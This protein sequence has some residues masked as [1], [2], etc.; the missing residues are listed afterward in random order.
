MDN[1]GSER[2]V[3]QGGHVAGDG[4]GVPKHARALTFENFPVGYFRMV[5]HLVDSHLP[6]ACGL[7]DNS[8]EAC[9]NAVHRRQ[10]ASVGCYAFL[11]K[12]KDLFFVTSHR[13]M[14]ETDVREFLP[15]CK[16]RWLRLSRTNS[17]LSG[18]ES[19]TYL[20]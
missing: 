7:Y 5:A 13:D 17:L 8:T 14:L 11:H 3:G 9:T 2:D 15:K 12:K 18:V 4:H 16:C 10:N 1:R 6:S 19:V 20:N